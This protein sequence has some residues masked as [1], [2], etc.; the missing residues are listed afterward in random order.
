MEKRKFAD[1]DETDYF[2]SL[3]FCAD[4]VWSSEFICDIIRIFTLFHSPEYLVKQL[5]KGEFVGTGRVLFDVLDTVLLSLHPESEV[6]WEECSGR[7]REGLKEL[8]CF[9][10]LIHLKEVTKAEMDHLLENLPNT[11]ASQLGKCCTR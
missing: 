5:E 1:E 7:T 6:N 8:H 9:S 4:L 10:S 2:D 11:Y 3:V